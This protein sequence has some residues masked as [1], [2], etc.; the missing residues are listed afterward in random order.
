MWK[1]QLIWCCVPVAVVLREVWRPAEEPVGD[2]GSRDEGDCQSPGEK[3]V[4]L[5]HEVF[6]KHK[7][8]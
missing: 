2:G 3:H 5:S 1:K 6:Y 4:P 7:I 8:G